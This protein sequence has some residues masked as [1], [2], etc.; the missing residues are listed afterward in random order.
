MINENDIVKEMLLK[1]ISG[2]V[3][4]LEKPGQVLRKWRELMRISQ[5]DLAEKVGI[6]SSVISDYESGRRK[7]PG[8]GIIRRLV[9]GMIELEM[10]RGGD[11]IKEFS[12]ETGS[13]INIILDLKEFVEPLRVSKFCRLIGAKLFYGDD[14]Q[15]IYGYTIIDSI[16]AILNFS[17]NEL[18]R[19]YGSTTS[20]ALIFTKVSIGRSPMI[21]IKVT[22]LK[23]SLVV[24]H[25]VERPD[26]LALKIAEI[27]D[28]PLAVVTK[29]IDQ[30]INSLRK[31]D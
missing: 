22:G 1:K 16:K 12:M 29:N 26:E 23:P 2:E 14:K 15:P 8:V 13:I 10:K 17:P 30:I 7:S 25:G 3:V 31:M 21:A 6:S 4:A 28:I 24:L 9:N 5:K 20:R 19:I 11:I 27:E 18:V